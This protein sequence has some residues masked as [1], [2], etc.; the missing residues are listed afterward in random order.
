MGIILFVF[1]KISFLLCCL[2]L[3]NFAFFEIS[4]QEQEK[5]VFKCTCW[6]ELLVIL[7]TKW[8]IKVSA[9]GLSYSLNFLHSPYMVMHFGDLMWSFLTMTKRKTEKFHHV[10]IEGI[11]KL[12]Y[13]SNFGAFA[14][15]GMCG[16]QE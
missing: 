5:K 11:A 13:S 3:D 4:V 2:S 7:I 8:S 14:W 1:V 15:C 6:C 9:K 10:T 12:I 16:Y